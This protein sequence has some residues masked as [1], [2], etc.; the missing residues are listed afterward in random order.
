MGPRNFPSLQKASAMRPF[1]W[2]SLKREVEQFL[3]ELALST[4]GIYM[5][6]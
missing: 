4:T 6:F 5:D 3:G 2:K 1:N